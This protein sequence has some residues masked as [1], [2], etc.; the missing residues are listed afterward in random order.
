MSTST[1][2]APTPTA[3]PPA[4]PTIPNPPNTTT[5]AATSLSVWVLVLDGME[6]EPVRVVVPSDADVYQLIRITLLE[7]RLDMAPGLAQL[8]QGTEGSDVLKRSLPLSM[9]MEAGRGASEDAPLLLSF[10]R[11]EAPVALA[12]P[13]PAPVM[14]G[15]SVPGGVPVGVLPPATAPAA[16]ANG[17]GG[18]GSDVPMDVNAELRSLQESVAAKRKVRSAFNEQPLRD[19]RLC[20][21]QGEVA[22]TFC[23]KYGQH[24]R[25]T[26]AVAAEMVDAH[27]S[28]V[29]PVPKKK[30]IQRGCILCSESVV[31][32]EVSK[33]G[34]KLAGR[35]STF[36]CNLC[37]VPLC[38][39]P[40]RGQFN[41]LS[42]FERFHYD[43]VLSQRRDYR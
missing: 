19:L 4:A 40:P 35:K 11:A 25:Q 24:R 41:M 13:P 42:C 15:P 36:K 5:F 30:W 16:N 20:G 29:G 22:R 18:A 9:V 32:P 34:R 1:S 2:T 3:P 14:P 21:V 28:I 8:R 33:K 43:P 23:N 10:R 39:K 17:G 7:E 27:D 31:A 12:P 38:M 6:R 26:M 37:Q